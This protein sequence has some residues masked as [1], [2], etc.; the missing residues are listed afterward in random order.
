MMTERAVGGSLYV[1]LSGLE[2]GEGTASKLS[3]IIT[4]SACVKSAVRRRICTPV[5]CRPLREYMVDNGASRFL[6]LEGGSLVVRHQLCIA[7][8]AGSTY[9]IHFSESCPSGVSSFTYSDCCP[10]C[11]LILFVS[12]APNPLAAR[13]RRP[14]SHRSEPSS[15]PP[16]FRHPFTL[17]DV[18]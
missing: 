11:Q 12:T 4:L 16:S 5:L 13:L 1:E 7:V 3:C 8:S 15:L 14:G 10:S 17:S 18:D 2:M 9:S 6:H